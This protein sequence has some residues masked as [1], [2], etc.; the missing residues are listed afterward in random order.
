MKT[1]DDRGILAC[2]ENEYFSY[3]TSTVNDRR[4]IGTF[5]SIL[6]LDDPNTRTCFTNISSVN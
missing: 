4:S 5:N 6:K 1:M 3:V 2:T